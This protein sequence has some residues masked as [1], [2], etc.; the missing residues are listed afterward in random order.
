MISSDP[1]FRKSPIEESIPHAIW[2]KVLLALEMLFDIKRHLFHIT[3]R[4]KEKQFSIYLASPLGMWG[5]TIFT[6]SHSCSSRFF[7]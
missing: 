4:E 2:Q 3:F 5:L 7:W 1:I 6:N